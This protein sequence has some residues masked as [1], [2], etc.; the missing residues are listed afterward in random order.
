MRMGRVW[1]FGVRSIASMM[2]VSGLAFVALTSIG[3]SAA[4]AD[5]VCVS[6]DNQQVVKIG[7]N[8]NCG[9][10]LQDAGG[11]GMND[12]RWKSAVQ[13]SCSAF[14]K[15]KLAWSSLTVCSDLRGPTS[16]M[17][18]YYREWTVYPY[19]WSQIS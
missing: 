8:N 6:S 2:C 7:D 9:K 19:K 10:F 13:W 5:K 11:A 4:H 3:V 1:K 14:A 16:Y 17:G 18:H 15:N 12:A